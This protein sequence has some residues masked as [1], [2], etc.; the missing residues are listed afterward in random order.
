MMLA[1]QRV[2]SSG[3]K[4]FRAGSDGFCIQGGSISNR[5]KSNVYIT[6]GQADILAN[7][8]G[9]ALDPTDNSTAIESQRPSRALPA[10]DAANLHVRIHD[11][12]Y[13]PRNSSGI[14][15]NP[16]AP[17]I[18]PRPSQLHPYGPSG[19]RPRP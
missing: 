18:I 6:S 12:L 4:D 17:I 13:R 15:V 2:R 3:A 8:F 11:S 10:L 5:T 19:S 9:S 1:K 14:Q 16:I 7:F